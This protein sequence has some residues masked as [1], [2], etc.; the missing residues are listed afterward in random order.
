[1]PSFLLSS[2]NRSYQRALL[3][4]FGQLSDLR[5]NCENTEVLW[6]GS[7]E[8]LIKFCAQKKNLKWTDGKVKDLG[9]WF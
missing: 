6:I 1:M 8:G 4:S 5:V 3:D 9:V 2:L 7:K